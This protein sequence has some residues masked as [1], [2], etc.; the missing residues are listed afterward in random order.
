M[1]RG[2]WPE[3][4]GDAEIWKKVAVGAGCFLTLLPLPFLFG[5]VHQD[6]EAENQRIESKEAPGKLPGLDDPLGA[7]GNGLVP[8]FLF[9][10]ILMLMT[11]PT[12]VVLVSAGK[13]YAFFKSE[14]SLG[15]FSTLLAAVFGLLAL[16][17]Q[18]V[19][20][21]MFPV[22]LAQ[23]AR[24]MNFKPAIDPMANFGYVMQ[25]GSKYW[26]KA[27]GLWLFLAGSMLLFVLGWPNYVSL[28][29]FVG[30]AGLGYASL[31]VS[32][33]Y[34]LYQLKTKL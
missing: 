20:S 12:V 9:V 17:A 21:A 28:P 31:V 18:F 25:M 32:S 29:L 30:L 33:R 3:I 11:A 14:I 15:L 19:I 1:E 34:A 4:S 6:L 16:A 22:S 10:M 5:T 23:Y 13:T 7:L 2:S 27:S 26:H 8:C 24:G